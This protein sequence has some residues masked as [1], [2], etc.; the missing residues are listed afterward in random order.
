MNYIVVGQENSTH[1]DLYYEDHGAGKPVV[2]DKI[3]RFVDGA[4]V[5]KVGEL[6]FSLSANFISDMLL[7][8]D[9]ST[10]VLDPFAE[11]T[12][13][14]MYGDIKDPITKQRYERDPRWIAQKAE[15]YLKLEQ[16]EKAL[17]WIE[18]QV[19]RARFGLQELR[20]GVDLRGEQ[21][22]HIQGS[23]ALREA[24]ADAFLLGK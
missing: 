7:V 10:A 24:L 16:E 14:V 23:R 22:G 4:S 8:P 2:L 21:E 5:K 3:Q 9:P 19:V 17:P 18:A 13:L 6:T 11:F 12:T 15:L 20:V 1:I